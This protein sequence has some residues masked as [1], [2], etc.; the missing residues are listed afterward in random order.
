MIEEEYSG[1]ETLTAE[2]RNTTIEDGWVG[3]CWKLNGGETLISQAFEGSA[4]EIYSAM[5]MGQEL[6]DY[7]VG[8]IQPDG[9]IIWIHLEEDGYHEFVLKQNGGY[10][11]AVKNNQDK[12]LQ[13]D[14]S[15]RSS[16]SR[17]ENSFIEIEEK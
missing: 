13:I 8:L 16:D 3:I 1:S 14:I 10:R 15:M 9:E 4:G 7:D 11:L 6:S 12:E 17:K 5:M 2:E